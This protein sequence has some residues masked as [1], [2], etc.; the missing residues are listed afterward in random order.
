MPCEARMGTC[1]IK[2]YSKPYIPG[3]K[4]HQILWAYTD[5][6]KKS[7]CRRGKNIPCAE[8]MASQERRR[9]WKAPVKSFKQSEIYKFVKDQ[10][11]FRN[12]SVNAGIPGLDYKNPDGPLKKKHLIRPGR[13]SSALSKLR[14]GFAFSF[15]LPQDKQG[16]VLTAH[17]HAPCTSNVHLLQLFATKMNQWFDHENFLVLYAGMYLAWQN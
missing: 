15:I 16:Q 7:T 3:A 12:I 2:T 17:H 5:F 9:K 4:R 8:E 10:Q 13:Q 14:W 1:Q 11:M 6:I